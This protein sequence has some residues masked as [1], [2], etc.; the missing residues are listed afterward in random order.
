MS[1]FRESPNS[2]PRRGAT[3]PTPVPDRAAGGP[4]TAAGKSRS[5]QNAVTHGLTAQTLL[6]ALLGP[7]RLEHHWDQLTVEWQPRSPTEHFLV[8]K[9]ARHGAALELA[10]EAERAVLRTGA[11]TP[12]P[13]GLDQFHTASVV[14]DTLLAG[15]VAT[16]ALD[17]LTRYR[18]AHEKGYYTA[19]TRL[20][21]L[22]AAP[23]RQP[24]RVSVAPPAS[25][26]DC[27][28][29]LRAR[30]ERRQGPCP[31]CGPGPGY[32]LHERRRWQCGRCGRQ[33][34]LRQGTI[35]ARSSL[36]LATWFRAI[37]WLLNNP[38]GSA[39]ELAGHL[40]L[41][42]L[43]TVRMVRQKIRAAFDSPHRT[44]LLAG[45]DEAFGPEKGASRIGVL[46]NELGSALGTP[47]EERPAPTRR[48]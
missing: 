26:A 3:D 47:R 41:R 39:P 16:E 28:A 45:L 14:D 17:R 23:P 27:E 38:A 24:P 18:R 2:E 1:S 33:L 8:Q 20:R 12:L 43:A 15:S 40:G 46:Q 25:E 34:G 31:R 29:Y 5:R 7:E 44:E 21:E 35:M 48:P 32:W 11:R 6:P 4:K 9:M 30:L 13:F 10:E 19:L 22:L 37:Q 36:S 42:R